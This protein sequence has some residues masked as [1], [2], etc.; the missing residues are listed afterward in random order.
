MFRYLLF[1]ILIS[2]RIFAQQGPVSAAAGAQADGYLIEFSVGDVFASA[3]QNGSFSNTAGILQPDAVSGP[4]PVRL[5]SFSASAEGPSAILLRWQTAEE[6]N[7]AYFDV[8]QSVTGRAWRVAGRV[9]PTGGPARGASYAFTDSDPADGVSYYRLRIADNDNTAS[10][11][12]I[13]SIVT[14]RPSAWVMYPNPAAHYVR[15]GKLAAVRAISVRDMQGQLRYRSAQA[16][17]MDVHTWPA[18]LYAVI[19]ERI[20]GSVETRKLMV[21]H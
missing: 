8:E 18:G 14:D 3:V 7:T 15:F 10:Y 4:L 9:Y 16:D 21:V 17:E 2:S 13:R 19:V 12:S 5:V 11:S 1:F 6:I 20:N